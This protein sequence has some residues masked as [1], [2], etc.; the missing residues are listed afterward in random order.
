MVNPQENLRAG[1]K[2]SNNTLKLS[3][4]VLLLDTGCEWVYVVSNNQIIVEKSGVFYR[5]VRK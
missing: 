5:A 1:Y 3:N 4:P 2:I